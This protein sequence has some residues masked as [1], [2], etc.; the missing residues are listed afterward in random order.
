MGEFSGNYEFELFTLEC[1]GDCSAPSVLGPLSFCD[2]GDRDYDS[3]RID[4]DGSLLAMDLAQ[5]RMNGTLDDAGGFA[6]SGM[7]TE[8]GG[9]IRIEASISGG[10][11]SGRHGEL[12]ASIEYR[13]WG[14][15]EDDPVDC[16]GKLEVMGQWEDDDCRS[17][18]ACPAEYPIC[19][20]NAC[21]AGVVTDPCRE[22]EDCATGLVCI[23]DLCA[24]ARAPGEQCD[25]DEHCGPDLLCVQDACS[26]GEPGDP[27]GFDSDCVSEICVDD[28]CSAGGAG[29]VC[30]WDDECV[31]DDC[32]DDLCA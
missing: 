9:T 26:A 28:A 7:A 29:D 19:Y 32:V 14:T 23:D 31:S 13:A 24:P 21:N 20:D 27:C 22:A 2:V 10:F 30:N 11:T 3:V 16:R 8:S 1:S 6:L 5:G 17:G 4:Q 15:Y 18:P 12:T 25:R